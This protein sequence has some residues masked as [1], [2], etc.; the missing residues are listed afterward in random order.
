MLEGYFWGDWL[1]SRFSWFFIEALIWRGD[2]SDCRESF[3]I[4]CHDC[5]DSMTLQA[6][7]FLFFKGSDKSTS[8]TSSVS[9]Y[10]VWIFKLQSKLLL[11]RQLL[12]RLRGSRIL[13][14]LRQSQKGKERTTTVF[15]IVLL[16][17]N[18]HSGSNKKKKGRSGNK[19]SK[20]KYHRPE[21]V[22]LTEVVVFFSILWYFIEGKDNRSPYSVEVVDISAPAKLREQ[23][24]CLSVMLKFGDAPMGT[25]LLK[26]HCR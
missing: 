7:D 19:E 10:C 16:L 23:R 11:N 26:G 15:F 3:R 17:F 14:T 5:Y 4:S 12:F 8:R 2:R 18:E 21:G 24:S 6:S 22:V 25:W 13:L 9:R 20:R 1:V